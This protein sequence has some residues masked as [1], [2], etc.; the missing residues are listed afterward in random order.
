MHSVLDVRAR[1]Y[2]SCKKRDSTEILLLLEFAA[3]ECY[4]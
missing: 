4:C 2:C 1:M 3:L